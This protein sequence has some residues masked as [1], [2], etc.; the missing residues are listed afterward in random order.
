MVGLKELSRSDLPELRRK[1][2]ICLYRDVVT[3]GSIERITF[4]NPNFS[5]D[6]SLV[7]V[8]GDEMVGCMVGVRRTKFPQEMVEA[9]REVGHLSLFFV[10]EGYRRK[11]IAS[12]MLDELEKRFREAGVSRIRVCDFAGWTLF[13]GVDLMYQEAILFLVAKGFEKVGEAVDYEID[14]LDF[15]VPKWLTDTPPEGVTVRK[16]KSDEKEKITGWVS[17]QFSPYWAFEAS[18]AFRSPKPKLWIGEEG[19]RVLGFSAYSA[20]EPHWFGPIGVDPRARKKGL[21]SLLLFNCL[22]SMREEGQRTAV[23]P[24][25]SH[26]FFYSQVPGVRRIRHYWIMEKQLL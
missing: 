6:L 21:G 18:E 17:G 25:T 8:D 1:T 13:S 14:L 10:A 12:M 24:W 5:G 20:L 19:E 26:L 22:A 23:I 3:D 4:A 9:Q 7:A 16:A 11:G 2:N 15:H